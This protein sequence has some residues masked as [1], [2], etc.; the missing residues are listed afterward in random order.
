MDGASI[1][2]NPL[3]AAGTRA[4]TRELARLLVAAGHRRLAVIAEADGAAPVDDGA[5]RDV[6]AVLSAARLPEGRWIAPAAGPDGLDRAFF[7]VFR[8]TRYPTAV[9]CPNA[10]TA[11]VAVDSLRGLG[12]RVPD[13]MTVVWPARPEPA[14][15][16]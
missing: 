16:S 13:D 5:F 9:L 2:P 7:T 12:F 10:A 6:C 3:L 11:K 4:S 1:R 14:L 15:S 8:G